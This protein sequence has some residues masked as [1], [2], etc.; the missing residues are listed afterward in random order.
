MKELHAFSLKITYPQVL[1]LMSNL[2]TQVFPCQSLFVGIN[3]KCLVL[4]AS[5]CIM[6]I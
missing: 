1:L 5:L 6:T 2:Q 3:P 4:M